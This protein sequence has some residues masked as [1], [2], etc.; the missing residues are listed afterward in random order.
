MCPGTAP[1]SQVPLG[2]HSIRVAMPWALGGAGSLALL[3]VGRIKL[4]P[5]GCSGTCS[6]SGPR[7]PGGQG[8]G[9]KGSQGRGRP[10]SVLWCFVAR[11]GVS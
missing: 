8:G 10:A 11:T 2:S 7:A 4:F 5:A 9:Q 6:S 1:T 3:H